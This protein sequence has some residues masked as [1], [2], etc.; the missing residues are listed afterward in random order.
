MKYFDVQYG[1]IKD[2]MGYRAEF[3]QDTT[4]YDR[5]VLNVVDIDES[6]DIFTNVFGFSLLRKRSNVN[7]RPREPS[8][9]AYLV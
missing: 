1:W 3:R 4:S 2:P 6:I 9:S 5:V 7:N 8:F